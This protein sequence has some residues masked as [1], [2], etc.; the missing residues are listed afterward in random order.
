MQESKDDDK[1]PREE[2]SRERKEPMWIPPS[3]MVLELLIAA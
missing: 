3:K 2:H 1:E